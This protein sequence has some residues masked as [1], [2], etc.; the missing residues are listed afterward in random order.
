MVVGSFHLL[1][2]DEVGQVPG[3]QK[4]P[5]RVLYPVKGIQTQGA[6]ETRSGEK[7]Q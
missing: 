2:G 3:K 6:L 4:R 7:R 1:K 5:L